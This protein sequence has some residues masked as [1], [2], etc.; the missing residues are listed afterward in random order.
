VVGPLG[1]KWGN[2]HRNG[3]LH[4]Y[5]RRRISHSVQNARVSVQVC[6]VHAYTRTRA[7][8]HQEE[9]RTHRC[10]DTLTYIQ[11]SV[12]SRRLNGNKEQ[13]EAPD[14]CLFPVCTDSFKEMTSQMD[15]L[16]P[17]QKDIQHRSS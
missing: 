2:S 3:S 8:N 9:S 12:Q 10:K 15:G 4:S 14:H 1:R 13:T 17:T 11:F 16:N 7:H 5:R 6:P